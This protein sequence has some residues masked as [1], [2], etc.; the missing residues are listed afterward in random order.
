MIGAQK[1]AILPI[2]QIIKI[3]IFS[4]F[5]LLLNYSA[6]IETGKTSNFA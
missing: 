4:I 5:R 2:E 6:D 3:V 1:R